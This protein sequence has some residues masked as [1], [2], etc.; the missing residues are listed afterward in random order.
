MATSNENGSKK[1]PK[2]ILIMDTNIAAIMPLTTPN[3]FL[4]SFT[5]YILVNYRFA[6]WLLMAAYNARGMSAVNAIFDLIF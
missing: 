4:E 5:I 6:K 1:A 3:C 2:V